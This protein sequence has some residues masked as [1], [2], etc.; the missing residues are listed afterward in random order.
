MSDTTVI[1]VE[2]ADQTEVRALLS[3]SDAYYAAVYPPES[4]HLVDVAT[5]AQPNVRFL[6]AR[7]GVK[8][9]GC[10]ALVVGALSVEWLPT[11]SGWRLPLDRF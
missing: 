8:V 11:R 9:V 5:L 7:H 4:N 2:P 10:G 3:Q 6:V 1:A